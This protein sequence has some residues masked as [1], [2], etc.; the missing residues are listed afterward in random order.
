MGATVYG[1]EDKQIYKP[2]GITKGTN[3]Q[4]TIQVKYMGQA[5]FTEVIFR[6]LNNEM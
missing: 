4:G 3:G 6:K 2:K 5:T 1:P